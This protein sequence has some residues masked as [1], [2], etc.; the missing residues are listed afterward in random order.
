VV[1]LNLAHPVDPESKAQSMACK[2]CHFSTS[3]KVSSGNVSPQSYSHCILGFWR[4]CTV[5]WSDLRWKYRAALKEKRRGQLRRG[6]LLHLLTPHS[7]QAPSDAIRNV[8]LKLLHHPPYS[9]DLVPS[10]FCLYPK[11]KEFVTGRKFVDYKDVIHIASDWL[12]DQVTS[13]QWNPGFGKINKCAFML[14]DC[15][16]KWQNTCIILCC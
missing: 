16:K 9:P 8:G 1:S 3:Q 12:H 15:V 7:S 14:G 5:C 10:V 6:V 11:L 4:I 2:T 13:L